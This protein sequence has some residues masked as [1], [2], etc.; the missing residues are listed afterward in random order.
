MINM[1]STP[2]TFQAHSS[3][4]GQPGES[5]EKLDLYA[6]LFAALFTVPTPVRWV[7]PLRA[8]ANA[9]KR[10]MKEA[11]GGTTDKS[12]GGTP[13]FFTPTETGATGTARSLSSP[14]EG[15][16]L[17]SLLFRPEPTQRPFEPAEPLPATP[18]DQKPKGTIPRESP[19]RIPRQIP[20]STCLM[21]V[22][23]KG[24][25][26]GNGGVE[27]ILPPEGDHMPVDILTLNGDDNPVEAGVDLLELPPNPMTSSHSHKPEPSHNPD[28]RQGLEMTRPEN[29]DVTSSL[30]PVGPEPLR[31]PKE[32]A[33][34]EKQELEMDRE[35]NGIDSIP[36][37]LETFTASVMVDTRSRDSARSTTA[38]RSES[39]DLIEAISSDH[40]G[41]K[42]QDADQASDFSFDSSVNT[43]A[44]ELRPAPFDV[45]EAKL[46]EAILEQVGS[47]ITNLVKDRFDGAGKREITIRLKPEELGT[48]E[49]TLVRNAEG[50]I[51]A[52]FT[53]DN[54]QTQ[55]L[56][57]ETI[58]QLRE[59]LENSG[60]KVGSIETSCSTT[61]FSDTQGGD[62]SSKPPTHST[63][64]VPLRETFEELPKNDESRIERLVNLRA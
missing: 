26:N 21:P 28:G 63:G 1:L 57:D 61:T 50:I 8:A 35:K 11:A 62:G 13:E 12:P 15:V 51:D 7:D 2:T 49:I 43:E 30:A 53:T 29:I 55:Y 9:D 19:D 18:L 5:T 41:S 22:D 54:P 60:I 36:T 4:Q 56:L 64:R 31:L 47:Q 25:T 37:L 6:D 32:F 24:G 16:K 48:V 27:M 52:H 59:S 46:K 14:A 33:L 3:P 23:G 44:S 10:Q 40:E 38:V 20:D 42:I 34:A 17:P 45:P 39:A 58:A